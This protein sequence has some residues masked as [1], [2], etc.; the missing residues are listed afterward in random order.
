MAAKY[1][2]DLEVNEVLGKTL[3]K[4]GTTEDE[5][6]KVTG[7]CED[8]P[9]NSHIQYD[10]IISYKTIYEWRDSDESDYKTLAE[11]GTEWPGFY[12]YA[13]LKN[14]S[15]ASIHELE[16]MI[17]QMFSEVLPAYQQKNTYEFFLQPV[18]DIHLH[19]KLVGELSSG[20][21][22]N[23]MN[24]LMAVAV[25]L[26]LI[27]VINYVNLSSARTSERFRE[28]GVRKVLGSR[29]RQTIYRFLF[30]AVVFSL[31]SSTLATLILLPFWNL[32]SPVI[33]IGFNFNLWSHEL[34]Y[35]FIV[36]SLLFTTI[37]YSQNPIV[38]LST[39]NPVKPLKEQVCG[40]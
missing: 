38:V 1:F 11:S 32:L 12:T 25:L 14:N 18:Q 24:I 5:S 8:V 37:T 22:V 33:R 31:A 40:I 36:G 6:L 28:I 21:D 35:L 13:L 26:L 7:V 23:D 39:N 10:F 27:S 29:R 19:S 20:G 16:K 9:L 15:S 34:F 17:T 2:G 30:E 4:I 3:R